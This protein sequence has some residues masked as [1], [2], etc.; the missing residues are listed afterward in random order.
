MNLLIYILYY[1][2]VFFPFLEQVVPFFSY[3]DEGLS[4]VLLCTYIIFNKK[5][6]IT[7]AEL[8]I[9]K[10]LV[11]FSI[12]M[13]IPTYLYNLQEDIIVYV[14][15][16]VAFTKFFIVAL[17]MH[18][19]FR[20]YEM[21]R[22]INVIAVHSKFWLIIITFTGIL[23]QIFNIGMTL[24]EYRFGIKGFHF[25]FPH[26][27]FLVFSIVV[28]YL[29]I[30]IS[31]VSNKNIYL[32]LTIFSLILTTRSKAIVFLVLILAVVIF[33]KIRMNN[34]KISIKHITVFT[35]LITGVL[36]YFKLYEYA[37]S[38]Y[39]ARTLFYTK[40]P[41][42]LADTKGLGYGM[43][44]YATHISGEFY[45]PVYKMYGL[46]IIS[47]LKEDNFTY[48]GDT[49]WPSV[50]GQF[51]IIGICIF[52][53]LILKIIKMYNIEQ[54]EINKNALLML[55]IYIGASSFVESIFINSTGALIPILMMII[56]KKNRNVR[57]LN[58]V[59][60]NN[61]TNL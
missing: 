33:E 45:S 52:I 3:V 4:I 44:T 39:T 36:N 60:I 57:S 35:F 37:V 16:Y 23:S 27:T 21:N 2:L 59:N 48:I 42:I 50:I 18:M 1:V 25:L 6:R 47:G 43:G 11:L 7:K 26:P 8:N 51:G 12:S 19:L 61:N 31:S 20:N 30:Y 24:D 22:Y 9:W 46:N 58:S 54:A 56:V 41:A 53:V 34:I 49:F 14:K 40:L 55:F 15:D 38:E 17:L 29:I 28:L 13:F 10:W 5:L 32:L